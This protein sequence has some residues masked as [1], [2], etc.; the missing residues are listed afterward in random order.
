MTPT[1]PPPPL[2]A[3]VQRRRAPH[4]VQDDFANTKVR[5]PEMYAMQEQSQ[6]DSTATTTRHIPRTHH[7]IAP[8]SNDAQVYDH[9]A[10]DDHHRFAF[11]SNDAEYPTTTPPATTITTPE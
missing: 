1:S 5:I 7:Q 9:H 11:A 4:A 2:R 8:A 10:A 6:Q 3:R